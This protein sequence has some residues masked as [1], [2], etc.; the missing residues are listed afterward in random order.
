MRI[1]SLLGNCPA[2]GYVKNTMPIQEIRHALRLFVRNPSFTAIAALSL[3]LGIGANSAIFSLADTL[4][5]R[6]LP[7]LE[8][9]RMVVISTD[10]PTKDAGPG[11]V[12]Y[13]NYRDFQ[14]KTKSF[15]GIAAT[16]IAAFSAAKTPNDVPQ[17]CAG[18]MVSDNFFRVLGVEPA[19]GRG[20]LAEEGQVPA[21]DPVVVLSYYWWNSEFGADPSVLGRTLRINGID[22]NIIGVAPKQFTGVDE[23]VR[24]HFYVPLTMWQRLN[25]LPQD[26]LQDRTNRGFQLK[27]RLKPGVSASTAQAELAIIWKGMEKLQSEAD[28]GRVVGVR[29]ELQARFQSDPADGQLVMMLMVLVSVVLLIACANVANLLLGRARARAKELAIRMALGISQTRLVSQLLTESLLLS[30]V[31]AAFGLVFA[32]AG[33]R[34]LQSIKIPSDLPIVIHPVLDLRVLGFSLICAVLSALVFGLVPALQSLK[35]DPVPALKNA[36]TV[37]GHQRMIGRKV[38]V[39]G[40]VSLAMILLIA[41]GMLLDGFRK[42]LVLNPGF[43]TD[44][45]LTAEFDTS[46]VRYT[47]AQA[48]DFFRELKDRTK[49]LG[50]VRAVTLSRVIPLAPSQDGIT[51]VPEGYQL[52]RGIVNMS[53]LGSVV[54]EDYFSVMRTPIVGGRGFTADDKEGSPP[55]AVVNQ[56]FAEKYWPNQDPIGKRLQLI[57]KEKNNPW[58]EVVGLT[59]TGKY[60]YVGEPPTPF[61][62]LPFAQNPQARMVMFTESQGDPAI[63]G[64]PIRQIVHSLDANQPVFN[65]RTMSD[66]YQT[67]A[68]AVQRMIMETVGAMGMMGLTLALIGLYGLVAFTVARRTREI[69]VRMAIGARQSDVLKMVLRQG[70]ALALSG[71][72][73]GGVVSIAVAKA[74]AA[75]LIGLG[76]PNPATYVIVPILLLLVTLASCYLPARRASRVDPMV[77]LRY[78]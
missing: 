67:R 56:K 18:V 59:L 11:D 9:T 60:T 14:D 52:P 75:G 3:A 66:F 21:R 12:S 19:L 54:D 50:G 77:A 53:E 40:Q 72:A 13:L 48:H 64:G 8:P 38:L 1:S 42:T 78:E 58:L 71:I 31:G 33:I 46:L 22:F 45:L 47:T 7:V 20:F 36:E 27:G 5:L 57:D 70:V 28:R 35:T 6:P 55:V 69:G 49:E 10:L 30:L 16:N 34:F 65:M 41:T 26:P 37:S 51:F 4:F 39:V 25:A 17:L 74:M 44:H 29:T 73:F 32:Y 68:I 63:L 61:L 43:R 2:C 76:T 24:P 23:Y 15:D 62:Y